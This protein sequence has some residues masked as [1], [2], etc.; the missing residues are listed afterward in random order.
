MPAS[1]AGL[2]RQLLLLV[3]SFLAAAINRTN[4]ANKAGGT[5]HKAVYITYMSMGPS[6]VQSLL[7]FQQFQAYLALV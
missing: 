1:S 2:P 6:Q 5:P 7:P 3:L 4:E